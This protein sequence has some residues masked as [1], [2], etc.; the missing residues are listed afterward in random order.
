MLL[1]LSNFNNQNMICFSRTE[2][3]MQTPL[4]RDCNYEAQLQIVTFKTLN[5]EPTSSR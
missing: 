2:L 1:D 5:E 3:V 4:L